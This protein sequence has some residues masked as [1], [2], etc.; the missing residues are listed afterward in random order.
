MNNAENGKERVLNITK[1][2]KSLTFLA[3]IPKS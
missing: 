2:P 3:Q 1:E